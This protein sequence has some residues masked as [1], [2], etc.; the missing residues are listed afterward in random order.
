MIHVL[1]ERNIA[2]DME[3]TYEEVSRRTLQQA[4]Q[5]DGFI[6]GETFKDQ[7]QSRRRFVLSKWRN[8]QDWQRWHRSQCRQDMMSELSLLLSEQEKVS[9]LEN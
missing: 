4:Y 8:L 5:A 2:Q 6:N 1:I 3:S 9:I 7:N